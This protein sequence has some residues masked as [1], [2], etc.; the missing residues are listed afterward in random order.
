MQDYMIDPQATNSAERMIQSLAGV[1]DGAATLDGQGFSGFDASFGHSLAHQSLD[2]R[3][4]T[5]KQ[6]AAAVK[7]IRKYQRQLG[8]K[9]V[10]DAWMQRPIFNMDLYDPSAPKID[11]TGK[12]AANDRKLTMNAANQAVFKFG[13]NAD[14]VAAIKTI[15]GVYN[16]RKYWAAWNGTEKNWS[17]PVNAD[18]IAKI[19]NVI[20]KFE[21]EADESF[22]KYTNQFEDAAQEDRFVLVLNDGRNVTVINDEVEIAF[23]DMD[24][25]DQYAKMYGIA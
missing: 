5:V 9:A 13:Y 18:S 24:V 14:I 6:A 20:H 19:K 12:P 23:P 4:W 22:T 17:V 25:I 8:G 16:G 1:C 2:G 10:I 3:A 11:V 15:N 7:M 21:F